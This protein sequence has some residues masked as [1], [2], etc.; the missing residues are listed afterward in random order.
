LG[1]GVYRV[2]SVDDLKFAPINSKSVGVILLVGSP[3]SFMFDTVVTPVITILFALVIEE[4]LA[5]VF[6]F[7]FVSKGLLNDTKSPSFAISRK[8]I[9]ELVTVDTPGADPDFP[10]M[11]TTPTERRLDNF[12][13][14]LKV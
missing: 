2:L 5:Y 11:L 8:S 6:V 12:V 7:K 3:P 9:S 1:R 10:V 4:I 14:P 13:S